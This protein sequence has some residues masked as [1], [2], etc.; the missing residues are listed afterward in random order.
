MRAAEER[1]PARR[2]ALDVVYIAIGGALV[3]WAISRGSAVAVVS[4]G[5]VAGLLTALFMRLAVVFG[6]RDLTGGDM[7][8][9]RL[10]R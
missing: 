6:R 7:I 2:S 9:S 5:L 3:W 10:R 1:V 8:I 4:F